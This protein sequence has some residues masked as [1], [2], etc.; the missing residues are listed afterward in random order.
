MW[1]SRLVSNQR[2]SACEADALPLS[3][4][5]GELDR[6]GRTTSKT[7]T[8]GPLDPN[9]LCCSRAQTL[10]VRRADRALRGYGRAMVRHLERVLTAVA[11][12]ALAGA[13]GDRVTVVNAPPGTTHPR[14]TESA[15]H[16]TTSP[17]ASDREVDELTA[18]VSPSGNVSCMIE[19]DLARCDIIDRSWSPPP[20]PT[21]C[22]FDYGQGISIAPAEEAG[23]VCAGD[24][25]FGGDEVLPYGDSV[26]AGVLRCESAESGITC[27]ETKTGHGFSIATEAYRLF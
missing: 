7:S 22:E 23:F 17:Q 11:V 14:T 12:M 25:A 8:Q 21:D 24:T 26:S 1:W 20:R 19:E 2:P 18:F 3:Y 13:C 4:E 16:G 9:S 15:P 5:T 27:R 6:T 10:H